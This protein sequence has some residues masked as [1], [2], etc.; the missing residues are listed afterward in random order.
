MDMQFKTIN[1]TPPIKNTPK[2]TG[3]IARNKL[4]TVTA[5]AKG[6]ITPLIVSQT[7]NTPTQESGRILSRW[8]SQGWIK[9]IKRGVYIPLP[10]EDPS[11]ESTVEDSWVL[12]ERLFAP[13][14]ISGFSAIKYWDFSEQLFETTTFFTTK[15]IS[16]RHPL[17]GNT[18]FYLK[19]ISAHKIFGTKTVWLENA[20]IQVADPTKI[21]IDALDDPATC[22]GMRFVKDVFIEYKKSEFYDVE[23]LVSY[24]NKMNN[25][26]I[27]KRLGFLLESMKLHDIV[28]KYDLL[29][30]ISSGYS[31]FDP[32][33]KSTAIIRRWNLK[34][35]DSWKKND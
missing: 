23:K 25:K 22:G 12:A 17:I 35:P 21:I 19:T 2:K 10:I 32:R 15:K 14:Y 26:T 1:K 11:G 3:T 24:A 7:L 34:I 27:F 18:R 28:E 13:G 8:K 6:I 4:A 30:K 29:N 20:K 5:K 33:V 9:K 16:N 31:M